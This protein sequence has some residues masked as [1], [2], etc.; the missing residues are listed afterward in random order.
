MRRAF[1][2]LAALL[3]LAVVALF[4][5]AASGAFDTAPNDEPFQSHR[6]L[7]YGVV[8]IAVLVTVSA[9][10]ARTPGP[11]MRRAVRRGGR[12]G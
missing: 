2:G 12:P 10:L 11:L 4:F 6:A 1:A 7:G 5:L 8:L 3:M 9:A